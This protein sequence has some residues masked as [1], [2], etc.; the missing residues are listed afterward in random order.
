M[1]TGY[2]LLMTTFNA[3]WL[4]HAIALIEA[5]YQHSADSHPI[6]MAA[7]MRINRQRA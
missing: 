6:A 2:A 4:H 7:E 1:G 3:T 5:A